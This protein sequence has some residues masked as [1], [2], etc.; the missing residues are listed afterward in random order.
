M[1]ELFNQLDW[2]DFSSLGSNEQKK[3]VKQQAEEQFIG[4]NE[5]ACERYDSRV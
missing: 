4:A 3:R 2:E 1:T 5:E